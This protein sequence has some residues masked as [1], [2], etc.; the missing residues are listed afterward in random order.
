M[1]RYVE[2][3]LVA[4]LSTMA[5]SIA[6]MGGG[7]II[8]PVLDALRHYDVETIGVLS[9][10]TVLSMSMVSVVKQWLQGM[11][12][13]PSTACPLVIGSIIGGAIGQALLKSIIAVTAAGSS[14]TAIQNL[15]LIIMIL[16]VFLFMKNKTRVKSLTLKGLIPSVLTGG[17]LGVTSSFLSIGGGP[18]NVA[19][20]IFIFSF[21]TKMA[22]VYSLMVILFSQISKLAGIAVTTGFGGFTLDMLPAMVIGAVA[23]GFI[24]AG[25][26]KRL[27]EK[28]V[29]ICFN[30][31][32]L[33]VLAIAVFNIMTNLLYGR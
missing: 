25:L 8:K 1:I 6:G 23:G 3:F 32:Q 16:G 19:L 7:V 31:V 10:I 12:L 30:G 28:T 29:E 14:V 17:F 15:I 21:D 27:S 4:L 9:A 22:T 18:I 20:L 13:D 24:G 11:K 33:I 26:N 5:G 2:Y